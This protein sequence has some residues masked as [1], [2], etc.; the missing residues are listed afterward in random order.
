MVPLLGAINGGDSGSSSYSQQ[1]SHGG[2]DTSALVGAISDSPSQSYGAPAQSYSAPQQSHSYAVSQSYAAPSQS[3]AAPS[4]SYAAHSQSYSAPVET[5]SVQAYTA[6]GPSQSYG[7][8]SQSYISSGYDNQQSSNGG[9]VGSH[10]FGGSSAEA[11]YASGHN[12]Y[13]SI[14]TQN[15]A[16]SS[17]ADSYSGVDSYRPPP[18]GKYF[19]FQFQLNNAI[20]Q[21]F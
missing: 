16:S 20:N 4:Q 5:I 21:M 17:G 10:S 8:P 14:S 3:Y 11:S 6:S 9:F 18:S 2:L 7:A 13:N 19:V 15:L 1:Y 12:N